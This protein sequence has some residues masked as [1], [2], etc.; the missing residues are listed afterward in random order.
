[1]LYTVY[2]ITNKIDGKFYIG[3]H[4]TRDLNDGYMGSG[5]Y[6]K[7]A[8]KKHG[9][10]NF[11]KEILHVFDSEKEM[12][13]KEKELVVLSEEAYNLCDGGQGG[14]GYI[15][16]NILT[17][18]DYRRRGLAG[19]KKWKE[20]YNPDN[21]EVY[22]K[23]CD[24]VSQRM[25]DLYA[26]NEEYRE[27]KRLQM[28]EMNKRRKGLPG[29]KH[30]PETREKMSETRKGRVPWNKGIPRSEEDK[31]KISQAVRKSLMR[32]GAEV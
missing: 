1:M 5:K 19:R 7:S 23:Y 12:N 28:I 11:S 9:L 17:T 25:H 20:K 2:K 30:T 10:E 14:F 18:D 22:K 16:R 3:K 8:I 32:I 31:K 13:E 26:N 6:L 24:Q 21:G 27:S 15:N 29:A 4:Q